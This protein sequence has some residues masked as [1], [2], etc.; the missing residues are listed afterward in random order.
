[1]RLFC[2]HHAGGSA[3]MFRNWNFALRPLAA[4][5]PVELPERTSFRTFAELVDS[6][7]AQLEPDLTGPHAFFGHSFG[8]M[9][10]YRLACRRQR[11]G[12]SPTALFLSA[13]E[14]PSQDVPLSG[15]L[16]DSQLATV[17]SQL[18]GLGDEL[19][20]WP[21][22]QA[23]AVETARDD[24][25]LLRTDDEESA[26]VLGCPIHAFV[27]EDDPLVTETD[28]WGWNSRTTGTFTV[29]AFPGG[30]FYLTEPEPVQHWIKKLLSAGMRGTAAC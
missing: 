19:S 6:V 23:R 9:L 1:M 10:A 25:R 5:V 27:G 20:D 29:R 4:V 13:I 18:G 28:M 24:L 2:F 15:C 21:E 16:D 22:L 26:D 11:T 17:L 12:H 14:P 3:S 7:E 30:H 8:G